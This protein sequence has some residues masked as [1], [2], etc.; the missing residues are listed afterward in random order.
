MQDVAAPLSHESF[1]RGLRAIWN[2]EFPKTCPKCARIYESFDECLVDTVTLPQSTGLMG[3]ETGEPGQQ[4]GLFRNCVCG[5]TILAFC[6]DRRDM[7]PAGDQR[8]AMFGELLDRLMETG[9][10]AHVARGR[11]LVALRTS[12]DVSPPRN[13]A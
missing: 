9:L 1:Y 2:T 5:T 12:P 7:S 11:L 8:R 3:Y 4:V 13:A 6:H 10:S